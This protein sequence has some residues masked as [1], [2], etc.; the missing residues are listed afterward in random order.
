MYQTQ[1]IIKSI[2]LTI[3]INL[4][5]TASINA[6]SLTSQ[7]SFVQWCQKR[8]SL[9][10]LT[11]RTID[12]LR[13]K[14]GTQNCQKASIKLSGLTELKFNYN[15]IIDL[16]PIATLTNLQQLDLG[17]NQITDIEPLTALKSLEKLNLSNNQIADVRLLN[18][19][20]SLNELDL[21]HNQ[22]I[23]VLPLAA[24]TNLE[25]LYLDYNQISNVQPLTA[26]T[27]LNSLSINENQIN[28][29]SSLANF[30]NTTFIKFT[31]FNNSIELTGNPV[32]S[33]FQP[34]PPSLNRDYLNRYQLSGYVPPEPRPAGSSLWWCQKN[35]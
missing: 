26:L 24:L 17:N 32:C 7:K 3:L 11:R 1:N 2:A 10:L 33:S 4:T 22:I 9:P 18:S 15:E 5:Y 29:L 19:L 31:T 13:E 21:K 6:A 25:I 14:A 16:Q 34:R 27:N 23:D 35:R 8:N 20:K 12:L 30:T 28:D